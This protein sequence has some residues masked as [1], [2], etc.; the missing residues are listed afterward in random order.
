VSCSAQD[1]ASYLG[2]ET[3]VQCPVECTLRPNEAGAHEVRLTNLGPLTAEVDITGIC[4]GPLLQCQDGTTRWTRKLTLPKRQRGNQRTAQDVIQLPA[5]ST[6]GRWGGLE[7]IHVEVKRARG[8]DL[9]ELP[10]VLTLQ[11]KLTP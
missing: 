7:D 6:I 2:I 1:R 4:T 11:L 5:G 10:V 8:K 3:K 9:Y